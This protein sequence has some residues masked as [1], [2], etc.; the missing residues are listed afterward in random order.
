[1][2]R[3]IYT[4]GWNKDKSFGFRNEKAFL[5]CWN[6]SINNSFHIA[7]EV[8]VYCS[9]EDYEYVDSVIEDERVII[10]D[11]NY[12]DYPHDERF[13]NYYKIISL[14]LSALDGKPAFHVDM[15]AIMLKKLTKEQ[16]KAD[17][18]CERRRPFGMNHCQFPKRIPEK[19]RSQLDPYICCSG[20]F[21][22]KNVEMIKEYFELVTSLVQL[23]LFDNE[24]VDINTLVIVEESMFTY[25][26]NKY[27][28]K[29]DVL[30]LKG[31]Q[32]V[33]FQ[34]NKKL[35]VSIKEIE[36]LKI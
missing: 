31:E 2:D 24:G 9:Q 21:G 10:V 3:I 6:V 17:V 15:D 1:M 4:Y 30:D 32:Y 12:H 34:D 36:K 8:V 7:K 20:L 5:A 22:S 14:Y 19:L 33:H 26:A 27:K 35:G 25:L 13:W 16:K 23:R 29:I 18:L 11:V 28:L